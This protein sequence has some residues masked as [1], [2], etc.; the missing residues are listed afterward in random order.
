MPSPLNA[1]STCSTVCTFA[2]PDAS[3]VERTSSVTFSTFARISGLP[4]KVHAAED[5]PVVL[6]RRFEGEVDFL[7][8]V[9]GRALGGRPRAKWCVASCLKSLTLAGFRPV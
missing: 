5:D 4:Y 1:L 6:R 9:Q 2:W 7:P 3:V 8:R